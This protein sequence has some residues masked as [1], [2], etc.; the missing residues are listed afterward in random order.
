MICTSSK[1]RDRGHRHNMGHNGRG[2]MG[3]D[4][5]RMAATRPRCSRPYKRLIS[6]GTTVSI[7]NM[8]CTAAEVANR[9][10]RKRVPSP[11]AH[12]TR[13]CARSVRGSRAASSHLPCPQHMVVPVNPRGAPDREPALFKAA[14]AKATLRPPVDT[15]VHRRP[16]LPRDPCHRRRDALAPK[17]GAFECSIE[18]GSIHRNPTHQERLNHGSGN[19][20]VRTGSLTLSNR[21]GDSELVG[22][23]PKEVSMSW[24]RLISTTAWEHSYLI[25]HLKSAVSLRLKVALAESLIGAGFQ[26]PQPCQHC[27]GNPQI[28]EDVLHRLRW[29][30]LAIEE[31]QDSRQAVASIGPSA[32]SGATSVRSIAFQCLPG[33][34]WDSFEIPQSDNRQP[35]PVPNQPM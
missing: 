16:R 8:A 12:A 24:V 14:C 19:E 22:S 17:S 33:W 11:P 9:S 21:G 27:W 3:L 23:E 18:P 28:V 2:T 7:D 5:V 25:L 32:F 34:H 31:S 13:Q 29:L 20:N 6:H 15:H 4:C 1:V 10:A 35:Y 26:P 30:I